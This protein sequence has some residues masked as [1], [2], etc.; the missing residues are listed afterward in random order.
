M[1][2]LFKN[3]EMYLQRSHV[4]GLRPRASEGTEWKEEECW[5]LILWWREELW[6]VHRK[7]C[8]VLLYGR[9]TPRW[10][11][12]G[13]VYIHGLFAIG[14]P[15]FEI[16]SLYSLLDVC[17]CVWYVATCDES[18][19]ADM[20]VDYFMCLLIWCF[21]YY[22]K[23]CRHPFVCFPQFCLPSGDVCA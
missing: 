20:V 4:L 22:T 19:W 6:V 23:T 12:T 14:R 21:N 3:P 10:P 9:A 13:H 11:G 18:M 17:V 2:V 7:Q 16:L 5:T 8:T 15:C 1:P